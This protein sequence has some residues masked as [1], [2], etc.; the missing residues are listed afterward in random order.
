M[1][2]VRGAILFGFSHRY[3]NH[4]WHCGDVSSVSPDYLP[5][6]GLEIICRMPIAN[7]LIPS[8]NLSVSQEP[9]EPFFFF[10]IF[11][12][13]IMLKSNQMKGFCP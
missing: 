2:H 6:S 10:L 12:P 8:F 9:T 11:D 1:T 3:A 13:L 4:M 7:S 5:S